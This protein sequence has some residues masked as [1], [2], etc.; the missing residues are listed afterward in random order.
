MSRLLR[1]RTKRRED[2]ISDL[3]DALL[4]HILSFLPTKD[5]IATSILS[6]RWKPIWRSQVIIYMDDEPFP[7]SFAFHQFFNSF[8]TLR[9]NTLP[10]L[11]FHL[12]SRHRFFDFVYPAIT[13]H[14]ET[15][16]VDLYRPNKMPY[17]VLRTKTLSVLKLKRTI[18]NQE[19]PS[20]DLPSLKFLHLENVTFTRVANFHKLLSGCPIL[21]ELEISDLSVQIRSKLPPLVIAISNLVRANIS[22]DSM[23][24]LACLHNVDHLHVQ[25]NC[26]PPIIVFYNLTRLELIF[27]F[28]HELSAVSKWRWLTKLLQNTPNLQTLIIH[29]LFKVDEEVLEWEDPDIVPECLLSHL[30][31]CSLINYTL[32]KSELR[33]AK[34]IM[35]NSRLLNTITI[36]SA[37]FLD[38]NAKLQMLTEL[39]SCPRISPTSKL[40]FI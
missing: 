32:V 15:L 35:R 37:K 29:D 36:Q 17:I 11:S 7:D 25:L 38:T 13:R 30:T 21:Q 24:G 14:L 3:P 4:D 5:A 8:I 19:F 26:L 18:L 28:H 33:F 2:R 10:I 40:F 9:D 20:V 1:L 39:S 22:G 16:I 23:I 34:Y 6:K 31:T 27:N 12:K